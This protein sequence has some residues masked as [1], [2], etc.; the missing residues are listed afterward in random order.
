MPK[1]KY[2]FH[3]GRLFISVAEISEILRKCGMA[4][5]SLPTGHAIL[6]LAAMFEDIETSTLEELIKNETEA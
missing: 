6:M 3:D 5:E 2:A 1:R 4:H